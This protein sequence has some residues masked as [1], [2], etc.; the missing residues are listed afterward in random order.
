MQ[1]ASVRGSPVRAGDLMPEVERAFRREALPQP[2]ELHELRHPQVPPE[3][4]GLTV[5]HLTDLHVTRARPHPDFVSQL[6]D[7]VSAI[8]VDLVCLTGDYMTHKGDEEAAL[9]A[10]RRISAAWR[11][12]FGAFGVFGNH[13][14]AELETMCQGPRG[15]ANVTWLRNQVARVRAFAAA[16]DGA[17]AS[18]PG[19]GSSTALG[20]GVEFDLIGCS[21]PEDILA[22]LLDM[23]SDQ[24]QRSPASWGGVRLPSP[25]RRFALT[26]VHYPS[27]AWP[28]GEC[29]LPLALCGHTHGGQIRLSRHRAPHTST[30]LPGSVASGLFRV[31]DSLVACSRG[32]GDTL[33]NLRI[34]CPPQAPVYVL[35]RGELP[36]LRGEN[37][38]KLSVV[39]AW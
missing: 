38:L 20:A 6:V 9:A 39:E 15:I 1:V 18:A 16:P 11:T 28:L 33:L 25:P 7:A 4:D 2:L 29:G 21:Y 37:Y 14:S 35:R 31:R 12:R 32:V 34:N 17:S 8:E 13:D 19:P 10:L 26:L 30:D 5:L 3:L 22:A 24:P 36:P 23:N 27:E